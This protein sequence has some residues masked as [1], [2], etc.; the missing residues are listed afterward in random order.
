MRALR[1]RRHVVWLSVQKSQF[2]PAQHCWLLGSRG[3]RDARRPPNNSAPLN[4]KRHC[5]EGGSSPDPFRHPDRPGATAG[6]F[7]DRPI[8]RWKPPPCLPQRLAASLPDY[9]AAAPDG[10]CPLRCI[11]RTICRPFQRWRRPSPRL[12]TS[13]L[14]RHTQR[15]I[16][17]APARAAKSS[18]SPTALRRNRHVLRA[19]IGP[20]LGPG[21]PKSEEV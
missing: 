2:Q 13:P 17:P 19:C 18:P 15:T 10:A 14:E 8:Q 5:R 12:C 3:S 20:R 11:S 7:N 6:G 16:P 4:I 21:E 1:A 9:R